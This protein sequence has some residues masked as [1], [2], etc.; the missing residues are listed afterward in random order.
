MELKMSGFLHRKGP[1]LSL[2][3]S[4]TG[5]NSNMNLKN[6][7]VSQ[8]ILDILGLRHLN[9]AVSFVV[10]ESYQLRDRSPN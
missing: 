2:D 9:P 5:L 4:Y 6:D 10:F 1:F 8:Q 7:S 3:Q